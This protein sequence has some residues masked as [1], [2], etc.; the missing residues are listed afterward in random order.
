MHS[1]IHSFICSFIPQP[2]IDDSSAGGHARCPGCSD[3]SDI[4]LVLAKLLSTWGSRKVADNYTTESVP[5]GLSAS[6]LASTQADELREGKAIPCG[7][8]VPG[9][10]LGMWV[11]LL[12]YC[13]KE[14]R[15]VTWRLALCLLL[16]CAHSW[17]SACRET[18]DL[19][20]GCSH[21]W[22]LTSRELVQAAKCLSHI[23]T[24]VCDIV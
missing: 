22:S 10:G 11:E 12:R 14:T 19:D 13:L 18:T 4:T 6:G 3:G 5:W 7:A 23:Y 1:C 24:E 2:H 17:T 20:L 16:A 15:A 21:V 9:T 8:P